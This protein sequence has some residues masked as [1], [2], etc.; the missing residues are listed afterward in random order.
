MKK[1]IWI[2]LLCLCA[3]LGLELYRSSRTLQLEYEQVQVEKLTQPL[4][5]VHLADLHNSEFGENNQ[6]IH[7]DRL[8]HGKSAVLIQHF[9]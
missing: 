2:A 1:K 5:I 6:D 3:L 4:R 8:T 7:K 9:A